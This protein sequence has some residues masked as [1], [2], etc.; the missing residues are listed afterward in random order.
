MRDQC[1]GGEQSDGRH[2]YTVYV[3][4]STLEEMFHH[5]VVYYNNSNNNNNNN[6]I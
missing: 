3:S 2:T 4:G 6:R 1:C 5:M